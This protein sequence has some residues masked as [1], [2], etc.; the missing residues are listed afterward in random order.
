MSKPGIYIHIPF[1]RHKCSYCDFYLITNLGIADRFLD[2]LINEIIL[3]SNI[4]RN[5]IFDSVFIGGGTP[6]ILTGEQI[7]R[8]LNVLKNNYNISDESEITIESN[9]ED[10]INDTDKLHQI[11]IAG[12]NR[13]SFGVQSFNDEELKFLTREH[14][15]K[16]AVE[17]IENAKIYF[18]NISIDLIYSLPNQSIENLENTLETAIGLNIP[19]I[20]AYTLI[21]EKET[22]IYNLM[23]RNKIIRN[24]DNIE[25]ELYSLFSDKLISKGYEHYEV[26]NYAKKG[27]ESKHNL[28][29]WEYA[30]YLGFGPSAH[31]MWNGK[32]WNNFRNIIKYNINLQK[33]ELPIENESVLS[34][35][36]MKTEFIMLGLRSKGVLLANYEST[37][38]REFNEEFSEQI[39]ILK[40]QELG[41]LKKDYF[42]LT[43]KGYLLVDEICAKYF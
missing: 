5:D 31:S 2:N 23:S 17:V 29:Y 10:F 38:G 27:Y 3:S 15:A 36:E 24:D 30:N 39:N 7:S 18:D 41:I 13:I 12:I 19:H 11:R 34:K 43:E 25:S 20:S 6:S 22:P 16:Q 4:Y 42:S 32:R 14:S 8:I 9:P 37:F 40:E 26:S 28:K 21:Y 33:N 1:C 35:E